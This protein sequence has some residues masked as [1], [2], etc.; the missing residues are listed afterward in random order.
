MRL[1]IIVLTLIMSISMAACGKSS[2]DETESESLAADLESSE[3]NSQRMS[4]SG[5]VS[6]DGTLLANEAAE[7]ESPYYGIMHA[8]VI[9]INGKSGDSSTIYTFS[10]K[11]DPDNCWSFSGLEIRYIEADMAEGSDVCILF[12]GDIINDIEDVDFIVVL[13]DG[14]Y[15]MRKA[16]GETTSNL[17]STFTI[18]TDGGEELTFLKDNCEIDDGTLSL[19]SG[20]NVIVYYAAGGE[21]GNYPVRVFKDST[22]K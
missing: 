11:T 2:G 14:D 16:R 19:D 15:V 9:G 4:K 18:V 13:P 6:Y 3:D 12:S 22:S 17:M 21:L 8:T 7:G 1:G 10:D 20:E 5:N